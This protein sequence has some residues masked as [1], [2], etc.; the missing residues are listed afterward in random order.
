MCVHVIVHMGFL[1]E[2]GMGWDGMGWSGMV[3]DSQGMVWDGVDGMG[4][5]GDGMGWYG[6]FDLRKC[7]SVS[8]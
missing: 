3:W 6:W 1:D 2:L 8:E 7:D 5:S 4:W